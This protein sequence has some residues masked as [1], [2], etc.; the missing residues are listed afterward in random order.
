[1]TDNYYKVAT[2]EPRVNHVFPFDGQD[3]VTAIAAHAAA[4]AVQ[5]RLG[6]AV[7]VWNPDHVGPR[8]A[9]VVGEIC[10]KASLEADY[11]VE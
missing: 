2:G 6:G 4:V 7:S 9:R 10:D 5:G 1:M 11:G 3:R 8:V